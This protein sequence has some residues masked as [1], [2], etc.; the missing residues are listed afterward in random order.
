[1]EWIRY[2][3]ASWFFI[4]CFFGLFGYVTK[5]FHRFP[6]YAAYRDTF[7]NKIGTALHFGR[8]VLM[9]LII[10]LLILFPPF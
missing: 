1:M 9:N 5:K 8:V 10:G 4:L 7:G 6:N 2:I 3:A